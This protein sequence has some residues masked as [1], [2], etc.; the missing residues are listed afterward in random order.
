MHPQ[1]AVPGNTHTCRLPAQS[2]IEWPH[3][4]CAAAA[5]RPLP[6]LADATATM[7]HHNDHTARRSPW[8]SPCS[9]RLIG[10][11]ALL[12]SSAATRGVIPEQASQAT[13]EPAPPWALPHAKAVKAVSLR[14]EASTAICMRLPVPVPW[15]LHLWMH[16]L[17]CCRRRKPGCTGS[18]I[19]QHTHT[20]VHGTYSGFDKPVPVPHACS[21]PGV[22]RCAAAKQRPAARACI[23]AWQPHGC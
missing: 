18:G 19:H 16:R 10:K 2:V 1:H 20:H 12:P 3:A 13:P 14:A 9:L 7:Q 21:G 5:T 17:P 15:P 4:C 6:S 23:R 11:G 22:P 8:C